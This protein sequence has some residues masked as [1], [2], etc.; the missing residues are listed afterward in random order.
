MQR[1]AIRLI[2][3]VGVG[4]I[5][6][7]AAS[8]QDKPGQKEDP[9]KGFTRETQR[10]P[11]TPEQYWDAIQFET[12]QGNYRGAANYLNELLAKKFPDEDM[13]KIVEEKD[14]RQV[15]VSFTALLRL[16]ML[17]DRVEDPRLSQQIKNDTKALQERLSAALKA[18]RPSAER[19]ALLIKKLASGDPEERAFA[20][21]E[22]GVAR[23]DAMPHLITALRNRDPEQRRAILELLPY[24]APETV[25]PLG[26]A[27]DV[28]EIS[29]REDI[30]EYL[31]SPSKRAEIR[32]AKMELVPFLWYYAAAP[33]QTEEVRRRAAE[34][35]GYLTN[36]DP[37]ALPISTG[38]LTR[39]A[40]TYYRHKGR[41]ASATRLALWRWDATEKRLV[42]ALPGVPT[43]EDLLKGTEAERA[44]KWRL[45]QDGYEE[46]YARRFLTQALQLDPTYEP[47]Q[48]LMLLVRIDKATSRQA[49]G[50]PLP[51]ELQTLLART[52]PD[53]ITKILEQA[54][55]EDQVPVILA[56]VQALGELADVRAARPVSRGEPPLVRALNYP[57][58]RVQMAAAEAMMRIPARPSLVAAGRV[59]EVFQKAADASLLDTAGAKP[60]VPKILVAFGEIGAKL[61]DAN[62]RGR[63]VETAVK[64]AGL[65][66]VRVKSGREVERALVERNDIDGVLLD[67]KIANPELPFV[68]SRIRESANAG[69]LPL[70]LVL[71]GD[72]AAA[73]AVRRARI[74]VEL[75]NLTHRRTE[76][77]AERVELERTLRSPDYSGTNTGLV[78]RD[79][80]IREILEGIRPENRRAAVERIMLMTT[81]IRIQSDERVRTVE[82]QAVLKE[83]EPWLFLFPKERSDHLRDVIE[84]MGLAKDDKERLGYETELSLLVRE[85]FSLSIRDAESY[86]RAEMKQIDRDLSSA[87]GDCAPSVRRLA[88][89]Y[90][91]TWVIEDSVA[92][93]GRLLAALFAPLRDDGASVKALSKEEVADYGRRALS[94]LTRIGTHQHPGYDISPA[95]ETLFRALASPDLK[96]DLVFA[97]VDAVA[98]LPGKKPQ[99]EFAN[100]VLNAKRKPAERYAAMS[101]LLNHI[102]KNGLGLPRQQLDALRELADKEPDP[103]V[104]G[105]IT[106]LIGSLRPD[107]RQTGELLLKP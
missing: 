17:A 54:I 85:L 20:A 62:D 39:E 27:L 84:K 106:L 32:A 93:N 15:K 9:F 102:Q 66:V 96:E 97:V 61:G 98:Q 87:P 71:P 63:L 100:V 104:K 1:I 105:R 45:A 89:H 33:E 94:W 53:L 14:G 75:Q 64:A 56:M 83:L 69:N 10:K 107:A 51:A 8:A 67:V 86:W 92:V 81:G 74:V 76:L 16:R 28:P 38:A 12:E 30:L 55:S 35:I 26:A 52:N 73:L 31:A 95:T 44:A 47:A 41:F 19:Y 70:W 79:R 101:A 77:E 2:L 29:V 21:G 49:I 6:L 23:I 11:Q 88:E 18:K 13:L 42:N 78:L 103:Q 57:D 50:K 48:R 34:A 91:N 46:Y 36:R 65:E 80:T 22:L 59:V 60:R 3:G 43:E 5:L 40:E 7:T 4:A 37:K 68:L 90:R 72:S 25:F 58:R 82:K 99:S 24:L